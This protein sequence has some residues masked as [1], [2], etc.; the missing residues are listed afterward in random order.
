MMTLVIA[1]MRQNSIS[2]LRV[3]DCAIAG[4]ASVIPGNRQVTSRQ[5]ALEARCLIIHIAL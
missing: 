4:A 2:G 3:E 5:V 1:P